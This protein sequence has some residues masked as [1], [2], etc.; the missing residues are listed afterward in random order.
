MSGFATK[1]GPWAL[2][3]GASEGLGAAFAEELAARR[4]NLVLVA[5]RASALDE[6]AASL[7]AKHGV[8]VRT[9][10]IDLGDPGV[11]E[12]TKAATDGLEVGLVVYNAAHSVVGKFFDL[13]LE[14]KLQMID[15]NCRA[16]LMFADHFGRAM[17][18]RRRGG[19]LLMS[20]LAGFQGTAMVT[21][22]A[23][24]KAF[25]TVL[26][27]GLWD[28]LRAVGVDVVPFCAGATTTPN[29]LRTEPRKGAAPLMTPEDT[30]REAIA[31]LGGGP[32]AIAG[33]ANRV[34]LFVMERFM[35]RKNRVEMMGRATRKMYA[36]KN[37]SA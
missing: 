10:A 14:T 36:G 2:V 7:R 29:F 18:A 23:A 15:V 12:K 31:S 19:I 27:E 11:L 5:R 3:A 32:R 13:P 17:A 24:T 4:L 21:T 28:E 9:A 16:P 33:R 37:G 1:Y 25:D 34:A 8:D 30:A 6:L 35:A 20:S 22:Y 26:G